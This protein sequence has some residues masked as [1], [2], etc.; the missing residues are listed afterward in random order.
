MTLI[1]NYTG[2]FLYFRKYHPYYCLEFTALKFTENA[3]HY[4]PCFNMLKAQEQRGIAAS[5]DA[6]TMAN[7]TK[8]ALGAG[9]SEN[10]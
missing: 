2:T 10:T 9:G 6:V 3:E 8:E 1:L 4:L 5:Q 7:I